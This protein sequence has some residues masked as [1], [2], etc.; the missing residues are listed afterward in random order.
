MAVLEVIGI[1]V[2]LLL[3]RSATSGGGWSDAFAEVVR[4]RSIALLLAGIAVGAIVGPERLLPTDPL[5]VGLFSGA[6]VLFL[7]EM[8]AVAAGRLR[9]VKSAGW[10]VVALAIA[11]P[12][13]NGFLGAVA[14][15]L[16]GLSTGGT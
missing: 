16:A 4:G 6:L 1:L 9:D 2:A 8:G 5:F 14:G 13:V 10:R 12:L 15:N 11:I 7:L 3:A